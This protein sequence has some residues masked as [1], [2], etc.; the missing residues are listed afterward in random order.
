MSTR[1]IQ[2]ENVVERTIRNKLMLVPLKSGPARLDA[3]YTLNE[4]A[5]FLWRQLHTAQTE[6]S[7]IKSLT[8]EYAVTESAAKADV[9]QFLDAMSNI[10]ALNPSHQE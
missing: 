7:L 4:T 9:R 5:A 10:G 8:S 6:N 3:L 1:F 2:S